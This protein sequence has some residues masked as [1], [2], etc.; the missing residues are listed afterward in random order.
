MVDVS[1]VTA[2]GS[3]LMF[4]PGHGK[5]EIHLCFMKKHAE[6][7]STQTV[8]VLPSLLD[9]CHLSLENNADGKY[10]YKPSP[11]MGRNALV[12]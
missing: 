11:V 3:W 5:K 2:V 7:K 10:P 1:P 12:A 8:T 4:H 6:R 9:S